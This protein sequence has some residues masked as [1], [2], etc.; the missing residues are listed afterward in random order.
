MTAHWNCV[1]KIQLKCWVGGNILQG[2]AL[3]LDT[4]YFLKQKP[5]QLLCLQQEQPREI[6]DPGAGILPTEQREV[7]MESRGA[8]RTG[9]KPIARTS[10][11]LG[12]F[13]VDSQPLHTSSTPENSTL[14]R[15]QRGKSRSSLFAVTPSERRGSL[16]F[17][18]LHS[19]P[20][21]LEVM[22]PRWAHC[23]KED[24]ARVLLRYK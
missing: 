15:E 1:L 17:P 10:H 18:S 22:V 4:E 13:S 14:P 23:H 11:S 24:T 6:A 9:I 5:L 8:V 7:T 3:S 20:T 12:T 19:G 2:W 16:C 21:E